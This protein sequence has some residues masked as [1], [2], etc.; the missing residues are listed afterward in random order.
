MPAFEKG[1]VARVPFPSMDKSLRLHWQAMGISD[2]AV[3]E[4]G[5]LL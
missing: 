1:A 5:A 2:G 3:G 4:D